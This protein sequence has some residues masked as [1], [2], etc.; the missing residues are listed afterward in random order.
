MPYVKS[1]Q[2][3]ANASN[4]DPLYAPGGYLFPGQIDQT[5]TN[6]LNRYRVTYAF[7][8]M[9]SRADFNPITPGAASATS[10]DEPAAIAMLGPSQY[11][12]TF[13]SCQAE[14]NE[15][16]WFW[17]I[18]TGGWGYELFGVMNDASRIPTGAFNGGAN[19]S[20][21]DGHASYAKA[22]RAGKLG[23]QTDTVSGLFSGYFPRVKTSNK[24]A[25][26]GTCP[27]DVNGGESNFAY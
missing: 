17:N 1:R 22:V 25:P 4:S 18:S 9:I 5:D 2:L 23:S 16:K 19:F 14:G 7:N 12:W 21:V 6:V 20:F 24:P 15:T 26:G 3:F 8:H 10:V 11:A 13:S 27:W